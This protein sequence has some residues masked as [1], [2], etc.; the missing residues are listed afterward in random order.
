[1]STLARASRLRIPLSRAF[2]ALLGVAI[3]FN[4]SYW[5]RAG[6]MFG[7][8]LTSLGLV[9]I[10]VATVGRLWC[11]LY[12]VGYKNRELLTTGPY[13]TSRNPLYFFSSIGAVGVGCM[14]ESLIITAVIAL[15][16]AITYPSV[17]LAEERRLADLHGDAWT[18]YVATVPRFWPKFSQLDEPEQYTMYPRQ[19]RRHL[20]DAL[21]FGWAAAILLLIETL[22]DGGWLPVWWHAM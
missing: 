1:M 14:S 3:L 16:F 13:S 21:W 19:F 5:S 6:L 10:G 18:R 8:L 17:I 20:S 9:L 7:D 2:V 11:N 15:M 22:H 12:I 4:G